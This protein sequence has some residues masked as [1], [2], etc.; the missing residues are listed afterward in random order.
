MSE[1]FIES[2]DVKAKC[3]SIMTENNVETYIISIL[4][5]FIDFCIFLTDNFEIDFK[6]DFDEMINEMKSITT[7]E[8]KYPLMYA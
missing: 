7:Y 8:N 1:M 3:R 4:E 5:T 2:L 6:V